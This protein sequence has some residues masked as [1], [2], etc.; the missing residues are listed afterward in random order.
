M[1]AREL[2]SNGELTINLLLKS[3]GKQKRHEEQFQV[4]K[5][6][7]DKE[8]LNKVTVESFVSSV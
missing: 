6:E 1:R 5:E 8:N 3:L 4:S 7:I 2:G